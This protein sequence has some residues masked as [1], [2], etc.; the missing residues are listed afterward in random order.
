MAFYRTWAGVI[1]ANGRTSIGGRAAFVS[2]LLA[3]KPLKIQINN[4]AATEIERGITLKPRHGFNSVTLVNRSNQPIEVKLGF[5]D[6]GVTDA[7]LTVPEDFLNALATP[8]TGQATAYTVNGAPIGVEI[9]GLNQ[10]RREVIIQNVG[11]NYIVLSFVS[12]A[13]TIGI[14]LEAGAQ[15]AIEH[16]GRIFANGANVA[17]GV[18]TTLWVTE[19]GF[20]FDYIPA[21]I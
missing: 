1:P 4:A 3:E 11:A 17:G 10:S 2:C 20:G 13:Q 6:G 7:R 16:S 19:R 9:A 8:D 18:A 14:K 5:G 21:G 12:V 15:I